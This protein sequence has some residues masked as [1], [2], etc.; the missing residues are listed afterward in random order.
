MVTQELPWNKT[1]M[2]IDLFIGCVGIFTG[3]ISG[4]LGIG[5]GIMMVPL[6]IYVPP[7]I[8]LEPLSKRVYKGVIPCVA[9]F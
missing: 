2:E 5:G 9:A 6:R 7:L 4:L 3:F 8:G 1:Y